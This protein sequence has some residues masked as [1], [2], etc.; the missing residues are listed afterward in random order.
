MQGKTQPKILLLLFM[1][2]ADSSG[3]SVLGRG[4]ADTSLR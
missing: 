3:R 1:N 4:S 2:I